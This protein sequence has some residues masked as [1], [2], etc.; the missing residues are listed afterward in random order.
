MLS[1]YKRDLTDL[2]KYHSKA[3]LLINMRAYAREAII[4]DLKAGY[5]NT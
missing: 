4:A 1:H 3:L 2:A 5:D